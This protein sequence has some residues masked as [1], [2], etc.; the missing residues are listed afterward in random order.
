MVIAPGQSMLLTSVEITF[1]RR[2]STEPWDSPALFDH[3]LV[4]RLVEFGCVET[5]DL[6]TTGTIRYTITET[7]RDALSDPAPP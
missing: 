3:N 1:L 5:E 4:C 6:P 2:L 7:G